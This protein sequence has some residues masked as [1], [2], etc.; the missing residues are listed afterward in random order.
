MRALAKPSNDPYDVFNLCVGSIQDNDLRTRLTGIAANFAFESK[1]YISL[2][3]SGSL[4]TIP[5]YSGNN[6][7]VV[8]GKVTKGELKSLYTQHM[9][10]KGKPARR[11]YE[12]LLSLSR[13]RKCPLCGFG[14]VQTLDHYMPKA[15]FPVF[16]VLPGNLIPA[17][18]DC[19]SGKLA[20]TANTAEEQSIHPY[21]D[22][23]H[24]FSDQWLYA[25]VEPTLPV[26]VN[27]YVT[28]PKSWDPISKDRAKAHFKNYK[29]SDRFSIEV[30]TQLSELRY[31]L[32]FIPDEITRRD[33]LLQ[34]AESCKKVHKNSWQTA[35]HQALANSPW[36]CNGGFALG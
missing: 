8:L 33:H 25:K 27:Y 19:N 11:V 1:K 14:Q 29:L 13:G 4:F 5:E 18:R 23:A 9:V 31:E 3:N 17:C 21:Y 24:F 6:A 36:Y 26:T 7:S 28:P 12:E 10:G 15:K 20:S 35:L 16:S 22:E 32:E 2:A 30:A 34:R